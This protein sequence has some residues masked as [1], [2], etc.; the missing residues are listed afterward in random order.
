MIFSCFQDLE[1]SSEF[2]LSLFFKDWH[3]WTDPLVRTL[4]MATEKIFLVTKMVKMVFIISFLSQ[5]HIASNIR[6]WYLFFILD[7]IIQKVR[8]W[9]FSIDTHAYCLGYC[10][11]LHI[12]EHDWPRLESKSS[13][14]VT[15]RCYVSYIIP[16]LTGICERLYN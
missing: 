14:S 11:F 6:F 15:I 2:N 10:N 9:D 12:R 1:K 16:M 7:N 5:T 4:T 8:K 3:F 13:K